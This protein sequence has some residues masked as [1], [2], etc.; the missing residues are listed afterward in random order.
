MEKN[1]YEMMYHLEDTYWW[2]FALRSLVFSS[3]D[4]FILKKKRFRIL[5]AGCG[6]GGLLVK[7]RPHYSYGLDYSKEALKFC[8]TRKLSNII[9]AS[10]CDIPFSDDSFD[11]IISLDVLYHQGVKNDKKAL[12][13]FNRVL[14]KGGI[15]IT[16]LPA[17]NYLFSEHDKVIHTRHRYS[18]G[19]IKKKIIDADFKLEKITY[20][21]TLLFPFFLM[22]RL[23]KR[24]F[25]SHGSTTKSDLRPLPTA[26]NKLLIQILLFENK[27]IT[28]GLN[29]PFGLSIFSIARK[30]V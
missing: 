22:I 11:L 7:C 4:S 10:V 20:R 16:N 13:E 21:N 9:R 26:L 3:M 17:Y 27:F 30:K 18:R 1:E 29:F 23:I 14:V 15:L 5:D 19:E 28:A 2:N 24:I 6:T 8:K 12:E 25:V